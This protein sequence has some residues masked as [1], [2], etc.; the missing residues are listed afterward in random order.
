MADRS[1]GAVLATVRA[2]VVMRLG[3]LS[4]EDDD[5]LEW[6]GLGSLDLIVVLSELEQAYGFTIV[7][8]D[9]ANGELWSI[10]SIAEYVSTRTAP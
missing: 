1:R 7:E 2:A 3:G 6:L 10:S 4:C 9:L 8:E 5:D